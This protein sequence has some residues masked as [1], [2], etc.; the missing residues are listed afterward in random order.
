[1]RFTIEEAKEIGDKLG[2]DWNK[3][4]IEQFRMGLEVE[5]EHA[6]VTKTAPLMT[7]RIAQAHLKELPDYYTRL[8]KMEKGSDIM[9]NQS[10]SGGN[11]EYTQKV[12]IM[13]DE[14]GETHEIWTKRKT[15]ETAR[16]WAE[17]NF[18]RYKFVKVVDMEMS[19]SNQSPAQ[20]GSGG[21]PDKLPIGPYKTEAEWKKAWTEFVGGYMTE[22]AKRKAVDY[23]THVADWIQKVIADKAIPMMRTKYGKKRFGNIVLGTAWGGLGAVEGVWFKNVPEEDIKAME[24][25]TGDWRWILKKYAPGKEL[26]LTPEARLEWVEKRLPKIVEG[27]SS[28]SSSNPHQVPAVIRLTPRDA[29]KRVL[30]D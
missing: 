7:G 5:L 15:D 9:S 21:N 16:R 3:T 10:G 27:L 26:E 13:V 18:P 20:S 30:G 19:Q 4:D 1:M 2:V 14:K 8:A 6:D 24:A 22:A 25:A 23:K 12:V 11:P 28:P 29:L 17:R